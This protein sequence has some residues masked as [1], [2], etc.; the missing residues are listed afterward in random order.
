MK[1]PEA[2]EGIR[3]FKRPNLALGLLH[4]TGEKTEIRFYSGNYAKSQ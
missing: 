2:L 4:F 1:A 3:Y